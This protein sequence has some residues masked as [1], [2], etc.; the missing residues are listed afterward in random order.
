LIGLF[1][2]PCDLEVNLVSNGIFVGS[3]K[4]LSLGYA[5]ASKY[6]KELNEQFSIVQDY[7]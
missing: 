5:I 4:F 2:D 3:P 6:E 7:E 1:S